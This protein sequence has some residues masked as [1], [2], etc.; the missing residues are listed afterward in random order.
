MATTAVASAKYDIHVLRPPVEPDELRRY[1]VVLRDLRLE[2]LRTSPESS[3][4]TYG[5]VSARPVEYWQA[6]ITN[7]KGLIH[8]AFGVLEPHA[9]RIRVTEQDERT[10]LIIQHGRPLAMGVNTGPIP[11]DRFLT[12]PGSGIPPN[13][14]DE[15]EQRF[16]G[17][18]LFHVPDMRGRQGTRMVQQLILD[19]DEWMLESLRSSDSETLPLARFR[20]SVKPGPNQQRLLAYYDRAGWYIAGTQSWRSNLMGEGGER[21]VRA[22]ELRGDDMD[23]ES[24]LVEKIFTVAHL[25]WNIRQMRHLLQQQDARL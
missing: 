5:E 17:S 6:F 14:P 10:K 22:A 12:P 3:T 11:R 9:S 21:S 18:M 19:R 25:E 15:E 7:H 20:G 13:R 4:E 8:I 16:H 1:A 23:E 24:V 2:S